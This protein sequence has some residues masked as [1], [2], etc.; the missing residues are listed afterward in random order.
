MS[1]R[2]LSPEIEAALRGLIERAYKNTP[3]DGKI[4][5]TTKSLRDIWDERLNEPAYVTLSRTFV[6]GCTINLVVSALSTPVVK[7]CLW[8][9]AG[10]E[11]SLFPIFLLLLVFRGIS[12]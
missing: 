5:I 9:I 1:D 6:R 4:E 11:I 3:E 8:A 7:Y 10:I 12:K 2:E